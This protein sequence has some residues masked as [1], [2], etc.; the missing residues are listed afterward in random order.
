MYIEILAEHSTLGLGSG[1]WTLPV[2]RLKRVSKL[3]QI[4]ISWPRG[5][6]FMNNFKRFVR[7][8]KKIR[9]ILDKDSYTSILISF[10]YN[11][12]SF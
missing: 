4:K 12:K 9:L 3:I 7:N 2:K 5:P 11:F 6:R 8:L 10:Q 1:P